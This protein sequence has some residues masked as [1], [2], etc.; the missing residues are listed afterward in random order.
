MAPGGYSTRDFVR[1]G[2]MMSVVMALATIVGL[3]VFV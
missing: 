2:S 1:V 3:I